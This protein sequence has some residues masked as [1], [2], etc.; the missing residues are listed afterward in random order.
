[1]SC[2]WFR[3]ATLSIMQKRKIG[4][5]V[6]PVVGLGCNNFGWSIG[7]KATAAVVDAAIEARVNFVDTA[8]RYGKGQSETYLGSALG[9]R[10]DEVI[11]ATKFGMEIDPGQ[12]GAAPKYEQQSGRQLSAKDLGEVAVILNSK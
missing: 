2:G 7:E 10:H 4:S 6:V 12:S 9:R 3:Q 11:I 5:L 8:D 1:V